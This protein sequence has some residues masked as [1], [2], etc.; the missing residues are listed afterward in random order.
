MGLDSAP[1]PFADCVPGTVGLFNR[2]YAHVIAIDDACER[3]YYTYAPGEACIIT[4]ELFNERD[5][6]WFRTSHMFDPR[7]LYWSLSVLSDADIRGCFGTELDPRTDRSVGAL[8][9]RA[10]TQTMGA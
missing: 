5:D 2:T 9:A 3:G 10:R 8:V 1:V 7:N 4:W 6:R